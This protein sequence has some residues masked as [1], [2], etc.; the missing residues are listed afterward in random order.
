MANDSPQNPLLY[1]SNGAVDGRVVR[2]RAHKGH[3]YLENDGHNYFFRVNSSSVNLNYALNYQIRKD[4][5]VTLRFWPTVPFP[6]L[7]DNP[8]HLKVHRF[9]KAEYE[10]SV[11]ICGIVHN[12][13]VGRCIIQVQSFQ[14]NKMYYSSVISEKTFEHGVCVKVDGFLREGTIVARTIT[15]ESLPEMLPSGSTPT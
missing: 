15:E 7:L 8:I 14:R 1:Y 11:H 3:G 2:Y 12:S 10:N 6:Q 4:S 9:S 5:E 13:E